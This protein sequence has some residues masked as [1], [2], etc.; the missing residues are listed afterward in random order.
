MPFFFNSDKSSCS[1]YR[2][3]FAARLQYTP[4]LIDTLY[5]ILYIYAIDLH[6]ILKEKNA[7]KRRKF[8]NKSSF[9]RTQHTFE[10]LR[11]KDADPAILERIQQ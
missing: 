5:I 2:N 11:Q 8:L 9:Q 1:I 6:K 7:A 10:K 3:F 4:T